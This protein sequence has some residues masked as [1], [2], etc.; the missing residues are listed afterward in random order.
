M[1]ILIINPN[2]STG[3]WKTIDG[4]AK[5]YALPDTEITTVNTA[6]GPEF[7]ANAA[8]IAVQAPKVLHLVKQNLAEFDYFIIACGYDP[9]LEA[10]RTVTGNVIG[11]GEAAILTACTVA[12]RFSFLNST[13]QSAAM[14]PDR[15]RSLGIDASRL[16][17]A[18]AVGN[19]AEIVDKRNEMFEVYVETGQRCI[20]EDGAG[21]LIF[22]CAGMS[23]IK[24]RLEQ[25]LKVPVIAG[26]ISALRIAEQF[27][28]V[29]D[30]P[31]GNKKG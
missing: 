12:R 2:T 25:R 14:V 10:C 18:R 4:T 16:A 24:E 13:E 15:L 26:V 29:I 28:G 30:R 1:R 23:D 21:A 22:S 17:S 27:S 20:D 7:I 6:D 9:G 31:A 3:M 8:D 11:I 5:R 19:S